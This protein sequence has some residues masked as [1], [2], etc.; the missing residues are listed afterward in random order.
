MVRRGSGVKSFGGRLERVEKALQPQEQGLELDQHMK[1]YAA[2]RQLLGEYQ[3][4]LHLDEL[5]EAARQ[6]EATS[7]LYGAAYSTEFLGWLRLMLARREREG[8]FEAEKIAKAEASQRNAPWRWGKNWDAEAERAQALRI[9]LDYYH[10]LDCLQVRDR[11]PYD[12]WLEVVEQQAASQGA[13]AE[14]RE[15]LARIRATIESIG[16]LK[17]Q[18]QQVKAEGVAHDGR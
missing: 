11:P 5:E 18:V 13:K 3:I 17:Q 16:R 1:A 15:R 6:A 14:E 8:H 4:W 7:T 12:T 10:F 9:T 2:A